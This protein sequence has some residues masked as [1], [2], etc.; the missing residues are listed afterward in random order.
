MAGRRA[1]VLD[2]ALRPVPVGVEGELF[3]GGP[4]LARGYLGQPALTAECFV[5]DPFSG[6][7]GARLYRTGD[8][9]RW[10]PDGQLDFLGRRDRQVKLHGYRVEPGEVEAVLAGHPGV[11]TAAVV[12]R[13]GPPGELRLVAYVV[14]R[15]KPDFFQV[16][17]SL[18][19]LEAEKML[20]PAA[21]DAG[22]AVLENLP[23]GRTSLFRKAGSRP[24]P[25]FAAEFGAKTWAQFFLKFILGHPAVTG[26]I[27]GTDKPEYMLDNL[28]AGRG[29]LPDA[30]MRRRMVQYGESLV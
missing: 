13:E 9:A 6:E 5:P 27:P 20:L 12:A 25:D 11:L 4:G 22:A 8:R 2:E 30:A 7:Q 28:D 14:A 19:A 10:L 16:N 1:Y 23:F 26:V 29:P 24:L 17:S 18:G 3:I 21:H 15:E